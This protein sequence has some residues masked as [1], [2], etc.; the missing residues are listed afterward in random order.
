MEFS[1]VCGHDSIVG[2]KRGGFGGHDHKT[3]SMR[4]E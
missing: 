3:A 1:V 2:I 4:L